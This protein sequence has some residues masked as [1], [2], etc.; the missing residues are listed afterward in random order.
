MV[1]IFMGDSSH[2]GWQGENN[3]EYDKVRRIYFFCLRSARVGHHALMK[4]MR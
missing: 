4:N 2:W 3:K 1:Q